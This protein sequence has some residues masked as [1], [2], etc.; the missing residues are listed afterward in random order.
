MAT[1]MLLPQAHLQQEF[2][3]FSYLDQYDISGQIQQFPYDTVNV[4]DLNEIV[5]AVNEQPPSLPE[6]KSK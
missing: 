3:K 5:K 4:F 6:K 1:L 2:N